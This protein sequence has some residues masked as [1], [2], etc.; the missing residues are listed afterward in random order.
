[1]VQGQTYRLKDSGQYLTPEKQHKVRCGRYA[2]EVEVSWE[3]MSK[4]KHNGVDP[5][6]CA[7]FGDHGT[8]TGKQLKYLL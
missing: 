5:E 6:V 2:E 1:M 7:P 4:S 3:K 8:N